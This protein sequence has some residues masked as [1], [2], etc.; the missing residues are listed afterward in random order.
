MTLENAKDIT[1]ML[2]VIVGAA[3]V[4]KGVAE[5]VRQS[6]QKRAEYFV[7]IQ[8]RLV[9]NQTFITILE[10]IERDDP[11]VS[12]IP[13]RERREL[14]SLF[15]EVAIML[16]SGL[17]RESVAHYMFGYHAIDCWKSE[18][19]WKDL[20]RESQYWSVFRDFVQRMERYRQ[21]DPFQR[22]HYRF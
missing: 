4:V 14:L 11:K 8:R 19:L 13:L 22:S 18:A 16:N 5:Y 15:E 17:I 7:S 6:A 20:E 1:T 9:E 10:L 12:E 21:T 3:A 2:G